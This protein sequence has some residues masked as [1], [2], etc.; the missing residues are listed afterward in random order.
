MKIVF[1]LLA[2]YT[3]NIIVKKFIE[4]I[5]RITVTPDWFLDKDAE[6]KREDTLI[7]IFLATFKIVLFWIVILMILQ[8]SWIMVTPILAAAW[9]VGLAF[10]FWWQYLIRDIISGLFIILENQY[11]IW[12]VVKFGTIAWL[13]EDISLRMT[14]LRDLDWTVH[15]IPHWEIKTVSNLSKHFARVNLN[16]WIAYDSNLEKVIETVN[17]V[18]LDLSEDPNWSEFIIKAPE[19]VRI[20][21]FADSA[22]IIKILW[23]TKPLKQWDVTW[24]LRKRIKIAFDRAKIEIPFPQRVVSQK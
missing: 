10:G 5:V 23:E 19:F 7:H 15:H 11:R 21:D 4:K 13:V 12:D 6:R 8:E 14:T 1:I 16:L 9:I 22:I 18:W 24:E 3:I 2:A 20:D 17:R